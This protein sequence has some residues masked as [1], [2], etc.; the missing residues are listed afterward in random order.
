MVCWGRM[1]ICLTFFHL[2][3]VLAQSTDADLAQVLREV[4]QASGGDRWNAFQQIDLQGMVAVGGLEGPAV[5][6]DS[7]IDARS[8]AR[9]SLSGLQRDEGY[10]GRVQWMSDESGLVDVVE[11]EAAR[12]EWITESFLSSRSYLRPLATEQQALRSEQMAGR[13]FQVISLTP[14]GGEPLEL[15]VDAQTHLIARVVLPVPIDPGM[16]PRSPF[17]ARTAPLRV[18]HTRSPKCI[19]CTA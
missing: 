1:L 18:T 15:W 2:G 11:G 10:D 7:L 14:R 13:A 3:T 8:V 9:M 6:S 12:R 4:R 5:S 17:P 16:I 19:S